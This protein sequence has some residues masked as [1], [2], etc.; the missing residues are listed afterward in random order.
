MNRGPTRFKKMGTP[1]PRDTPS[2][3]MR[4]RYKDASR[5]LGETVE[6]PSRKDDAAASPLPVRLP[7]S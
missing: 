2:S 4:Q 5:R 6:N 1:A 7:H 3:R